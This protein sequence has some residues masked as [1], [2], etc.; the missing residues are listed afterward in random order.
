[1]I[2]EGQKHESAKNYHCKI[3]GGIFIATHRYN[4]FFLL[5]DP[6]GV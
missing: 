1:M 4:S 5:A 3:M 2:A 6:K